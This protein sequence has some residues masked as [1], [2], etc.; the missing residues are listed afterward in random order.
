[1]DILILSGLSVLSNFHIPASLGLFLTHTLHYQSQ[2]ETAAVFPL[3]LQKESQGKLLIGSVGGHVL[4]LGPINY[5]YE[6][7]T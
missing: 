3:L 7:E 1:M 2:K 6:G 5:G 4:I